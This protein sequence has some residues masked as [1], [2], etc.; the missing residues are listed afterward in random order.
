MQTTTTLAAELNTTPRT[1]RKFLRSDAS[2]V[3]AVGKGSRYSLPTAKREV[4]SLK[5]KFDAWGAAQAEAKAKREADKAE[6]EVE[7]PEVEVEVDTEGP[8][9]ADMQ[10]IIDGTHPDFA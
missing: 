4:A 7:A 2:G 8:T 9:D 10:A 1:L 3:E 5:K 6:A